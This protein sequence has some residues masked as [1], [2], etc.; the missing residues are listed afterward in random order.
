MPETVSYTVVECDCFR[1]RGTWS[2]SITYGANNL[3]KYSGVLYRALRTTIND[4]PDVSASDW[5]AMF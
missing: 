2:S 5:E 4:Q 1:W 3:V